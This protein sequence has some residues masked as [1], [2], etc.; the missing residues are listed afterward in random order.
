MCISHRLWLIYWITCGLIFAVLIPQV[1]ALRL[2]YLD[3]SVR[4][5]TK[6]T[7]EAVADRDGW[8]LSDVSLQQVTRSGV[9]IHHQQHVRGPDPVSCYSVA[10]DFPELLPCPL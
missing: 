4:E 8:L 7:L 9:I 3:K 10:F 5:Q 6:A 2:L 1:W